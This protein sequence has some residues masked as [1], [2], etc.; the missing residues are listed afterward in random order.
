MEFSGCLVCSLG[1]YLR[2]LVRPNA[3]PTT[4]EQLGPK[5][6]NTNEDGLADY[7]FAR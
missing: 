3:T 2:L 4:I 5:T 1:D 6:K 7:L